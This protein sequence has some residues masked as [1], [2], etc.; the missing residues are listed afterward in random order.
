M[1]RSAGIDKRGMEDFLQSLMA[2]EFE[3]TT[4]DE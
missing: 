1:P 3:K 4:E 2:L